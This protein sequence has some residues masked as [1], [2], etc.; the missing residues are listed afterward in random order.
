MKFKTINIFIEKWLIIPKLLYLFVFA[1]LASFNPY[2]PIILQSKDLSKSMIGVLFSLVQLIGFFSTQFLGFIADHFQHHRRVFIFLIFSTILFGT[3]LIF[4]KPLWLVII[5][6]FLYAF[7]QKPLLPLLDSQVIGILAQLNHKT[8][9]LNQDATE[10]DNK[11]KKE[12]NRMKYGRNRVFGTLSFGL[13]A[14]ISGILTDHYGLVML[15]VCSAFHLSISGILSLK[16]PRSIIKKQEK[17][18]TIEMQDNSIESKAYL[19][20]KTDTQEVEGSGHL[21]PE[22]EN[23]IAEVEEIEKPIVKPDNLEN[24]ST[25]KKILS[26]FTPPTLV[27][28]M[29]VFVISMNLFMITAYLL[30]FLKELPGTSDSLLGVVVSFGIIFEIPFFLFSSFFLERLGVYGMLILS[31]SILIIRVFS[32][33]FLSNPWFVLMIEPLH[34]IAFGG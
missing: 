1:G 30:L 23:L 12:D 19:I 9:L 14:L 27:I 3:L 20:Q 7:I 22:E 32:Y 8:S 4:S 26:I 24:L 18:T 31:Q 17:T 2:F 33:S 16:L 29:T 34:G 25:S 11:I 21:E 6:T 15:S 5:S 10:E 28:W 13:G